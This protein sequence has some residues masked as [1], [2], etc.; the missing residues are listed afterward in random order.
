MP[1][2]NVSLPCSEPVV[3]D[4]PAV[5]EMSGAVDSILL[6]P[7]CSKEYQI[8]GEQLPMS[9]MCGHTFCLGNASKERAW[10]F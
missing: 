5:V 8:K 3:V 4:Q 7:K 10:I 9:L 6:C 1:S 2:C